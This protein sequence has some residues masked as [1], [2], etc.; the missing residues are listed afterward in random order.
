MVNRLASQPFQVFLISESPEP[1]TQASI[2]RYHTHTHR[3]RYTRAHPRITL[4][5]ERA[6]DGDWLGMES[7]FLLH[8]MSASPGNL[9]HHFQVYLLDFFPPAGPCHMESIKGCWLPTHGMVKMR[10]KI[11]MNGV[12]VCWK[13]LRRAAAEGLMTTHVASVTG[14]FQNTRLRSD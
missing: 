13:A 4:I 7:N 5:R 8:V 14:V 2:A 12:C 9:V 1:T 10:G 11:L 3:E 6:S